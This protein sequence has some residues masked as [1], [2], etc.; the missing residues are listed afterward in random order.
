MTEK[1]VLRPD[2]DAFTIGKPGNVIR[3]RR[4]VSGQPDD[5]KPYDIRVTP[6]VPVPGG[7]IS[8]YAPLDLYAFCTDS[9]RL[10]HRHG[11]IIMHRDIAVKVEYPF[12]RR[13]KG[14]LKKYQVTQQINEAPGP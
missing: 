4:S 9:D 7:K 6:A 8:V 10:L 1:R 14:S 5:L 12:I 13:C 11:R 2:I 3:L